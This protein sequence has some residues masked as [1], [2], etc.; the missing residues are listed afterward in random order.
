M[1]QHF[2]TQNKATA[3][4]FAF[5]FFVNVFLLVL[6]VVSVYRTFLYDFYTYDTS[7]EADAPQHHPELNRCKNVFGLKLEVFPRDFR[8]PG[9]R[10]AEK[11]VRHPTLTSA[12]NEDQLFYSFKSGWAVFRSILGRI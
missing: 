5:E 4:T 10:P 8:S 1:F 3:R 6:G 9:M 7:N 11:L 12:W 2:P